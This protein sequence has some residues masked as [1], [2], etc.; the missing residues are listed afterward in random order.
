VAAFGTVT[1][2]RFAPSAAALIPVGTGVRSADGTQSFAVIPVASNPAY[3]AAQSGYLLAAGIAGVDLPVVSLVPGAAAH[4][5]AG[6][7]S[8]ITAALPG[9]DT[10]VNEAAFV[11]G[12]D[13]ESDMALRQRFQN[14]LSS[15]SRATTTAI[16]YAIA[17]VRQGLGYVIAENM[18]PDGTARTGCFVVTVDDGSGHPSADL[19]E[20]VGAA[21][22]AMRPAGSSFSVQPPVVSTVAISMTVATAADTVHADV[23]ATVAAAVAAYVNG[24]PIGAVLAWSRLAQTAYQASPAVTNVTAILLNGG[25]ADLMLPASGVV[26]AGAVTVA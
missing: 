7:V 3:S 6:A 18:L 17:S 16:G 19:L 4:V 20:S 1:F 10:V 15:R 9:V 14:F 26:K 23:A 5:Q 25:T 11:G 2:A 24:L 21:V 13:A 8:L 22:E 12:L